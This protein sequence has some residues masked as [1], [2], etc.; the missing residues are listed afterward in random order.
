MINEYC[1]DHSSDIIAGKNPINDMVSSGRI[2]S[3]FYGKTCEQISNDLQQQKMAG[4][5]DKLCNSQPEA[6]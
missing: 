2:G 3:S 6:C 1:F 4:A 5:E